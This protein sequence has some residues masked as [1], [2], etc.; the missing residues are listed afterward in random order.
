MYLHIVNWINWAWVLWSVKLV[1]VSF[2][3][4]CKTFNWIRFVPPCAKYQL[5]LLTFLVHGGW[6][7]WGLWESC[8]TTCGEGIQARLRSCD[9]PLPANGGRKCPGMNSESRKC[10]TSPCPGNQTITLLNKSDFKRMM[11]A[12][13]TTAVKRSWKIK[14]KWWK[15]KRAQF[16]LEKRG[17]EGFIKVMNIISL[18]NQMKKIFDPLN[19]NPNCPTPPAPVPTAKNQRRS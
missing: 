10:N 16:L 5:T 18:N 6:S 19:T 7:C 13:R 4:L 14:V 8:S 1:F 11:N 17:N 15:L 3:F 2:D 9:M 12:T